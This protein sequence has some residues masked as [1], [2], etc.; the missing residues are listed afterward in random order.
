M[1]T[2]NEIG[3]G[4]RN[5]LNIIIFYETL[6]TIKLKPGDTM[7]K[8]NLLL[9]VAIFTTVYALSVTALETNNSGKTKAEE[10]KSI[11]WYVANPKE[12]LAKNKECYGDP[13]AADLQS[14]PN[15]VNSLQ[16]LKMSH[17]GSN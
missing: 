3:Q 12:A 17:V 2:H 16:A 13:K 7:K 5:A 14:T 11:A 10:T 8:S 15:C 1:P 9:V 4:N 6:N